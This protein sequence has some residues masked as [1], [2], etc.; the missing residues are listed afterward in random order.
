MLEYASGDI[1]E[2]QV[3]A[4]V[5]TVNC[6]GVMGKGIALRFRSAFPE[7]Y[8]DY[9]AACRRGDVQIGRVLVHN[10]DRLGCPKF[11]V[12]FP[13]KEHWR[14]PSKLEYIES[15]LA[16][17]QRTIIGLG[18]SSIAIPPL[19]CGNGGLRWADVRPRIVD[20]LADLSGVRV[21]VYEPVDVIEGLAR[22]AAAPALTPGRAALVGLMESYISALLDP[23]CTLLELHKLSYFLQEAGEPLRLR[24]VR[25]LYGPYAESLRHVLRAVEGHLITGY[26]TGGD[27]PRARLELVAGSAERSREALAKNPDTLVRVGRVR[28]LVE[29]FESAFGMELLASVHWVATHDRAATREKAIRAVHSWNE[30][31]QMFSERQI[32]LAY[33]RL[34]AQQWIPATS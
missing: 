30:R 28:D 10:T 15:G 2:A 25:A 22:S 34:E 29:G 23:F 21:V 9:V 33:E 26:G 14:S 3:D 8:R 13:T 32:G 7:N 19:G 31:K 12:N 18:I 24:F 6:V 11:V 27:N 17:L 20:A 5:N 16:D 4:L 1:V